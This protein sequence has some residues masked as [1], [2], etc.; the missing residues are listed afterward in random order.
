M[1]GNLCSSENKDSDSKSDGSYE[2]S[3]GNLE[4][5]VRALGNTTWSMRRFR[6]EWAS[7]FQGTPTCTSI[8]TV[9]MI[10]EGNI[11]W[12]VACLLRSEC[13]T[14]LQKNTTFMSMQ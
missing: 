13:S 1:A 9:L 10:F 14:E 11:G 7:W 8:G 4:I 5:I 12:S 3:I 6:G 2:G